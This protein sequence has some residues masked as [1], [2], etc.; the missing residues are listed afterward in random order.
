MKFKVGD[1]VLVTGGKDKGK[2]S[3]ITKV[4]PKKDKILVKDVNVY[5]K[6]VRAYADKPGERVRLEK[7]LSTAKIAILNDKGEADRIA[8]RVRKD[9][10]K[11]RIFKKTSKPIKT[12]EKDQKK[13]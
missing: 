4:L 5:V 6:H 8:I 10:R 11:E 1:K 7:P 3:V 13:K 2:K 9:G 12:E